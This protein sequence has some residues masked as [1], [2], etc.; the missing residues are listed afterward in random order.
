M[1]PD[2]VSDLNDTGLPLACPQMP[3]PC[4]VQFILEQSHF[5]AQCQEDNPS[6]NIPMEEGMIQESI[7]ES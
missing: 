6:P 5:S 3:D 4:E 7:T 1:C 2:Q